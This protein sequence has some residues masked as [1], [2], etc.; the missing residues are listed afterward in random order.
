MSTD[1]NNNAV[2]QLKSTISAHC[3]KCAKKT[4]MV[5]SEKKPAHNGK[6]IMYLGTCA[7]CGKGTST[8]SKEIVEGWQS[9]EER[10]KESKQHKSR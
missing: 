4:E 8:V 10:A 9:K 1:P 3:F 7:N 5:I 2:A 6:N